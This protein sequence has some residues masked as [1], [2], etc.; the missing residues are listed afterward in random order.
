MTTNESIDKIV[1]LRNCLDA[2][3][4]DIKFFEDLGK[5]CKPAIYY[6]ALRAA[7]HIAGIEIDRENLTGLDNLGVGMG[8]GWA[9][10][11]SIGG[12]AY[13]DKIS[14]ERELNNLQETVETTSF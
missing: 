8:L 7:G 14:L 12:F 1:Y 4:K 3:G 2:K 10:A 9:V 11:K 5:Y 6:L 13:L